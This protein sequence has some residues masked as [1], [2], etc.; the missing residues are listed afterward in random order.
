MVTF[1]Y[2]FIMLAI[3]SASAGQGPPP[4]SQNRP[5]HFPIDDNLWI[6]IVLGILFGAYILFK[7]NRSINKAS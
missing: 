2:S 4:P 6:L 7:R 1:I 3:Q 5:P